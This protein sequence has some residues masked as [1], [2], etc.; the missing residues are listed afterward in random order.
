MLFGID[1]GEGRREV[2]PVRVVV[3][4][5]NEVQPDGLRVKRFVR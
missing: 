1:H 3:V 2:F 4:A 5:D